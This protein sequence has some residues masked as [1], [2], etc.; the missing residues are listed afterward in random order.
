MGAEDH[1]FYDK[2]ANTTNFHLLLSLLWELGLN[3]YQCTNR[4][5]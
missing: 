2:R 5:K 3:V 1:G 4:I